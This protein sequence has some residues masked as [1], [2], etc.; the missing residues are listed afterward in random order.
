MEYRRLQLSCECGGIAKTISAVGLSATHDLV[1]HWRCPR[2]GSRVCIVKSLSDC[3]RDCG[4]GPSA[5]LSNSALPMETPDDR[6]FLH[7]LGI[8]CSD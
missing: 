3:W 6:R 5:N 4:T 8:R 1:V 7:R 2:C